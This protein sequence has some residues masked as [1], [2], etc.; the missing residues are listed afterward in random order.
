MRGQE[1]G[2]EVAVGDGMPERARPF[3]ISVIA[4]LDG[5][6]C[7]AGIAVTLAAMGGG[8][9]VQGGALAFVVVPLVIVLAGV[10]ARGLWTLRWWAW[11][12]ALLSWIAAGRRRSSA[13]R[14]A[15]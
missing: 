7:L 2:S 4:V 11:P 12:L 15:R 1:K 8:A 9:V 10:T 6:G 3:G 14:A 5:I 13:S